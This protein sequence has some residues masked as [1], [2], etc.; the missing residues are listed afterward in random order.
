[1]ILDDHARRVLGWFGTGTARGLAIDD[2]GRGWVFVVWDHTPP[3]AITMVSEEDPADTL[4]G[5]FELRE[6]VRSLN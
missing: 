2:A 6:F 4:R 1:M 3:H 5:T